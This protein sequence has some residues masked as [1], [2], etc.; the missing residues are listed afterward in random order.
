[1]NNFEKM[2]I[3]EVLKANVKKLIGHSVTM[4]IIMIVISGSQGVS[5]T[6]GVFDYSYWFIA[7][8]F[9]PIVRF[10]LL[11]RGSFIMM[12]LTFAGGLSLA[13]FLMD[14]VLAPIAILGLIAFTVVSF[15]YYIYNIV[16][17]KK[18]LKA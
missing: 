8:L 13:A 2:E 7:L 16:Q 3:R 12:A 15:G 11:F 17:C 9:Y 10:M 5:L 14:T 4:L 6:E 18:L 1:M